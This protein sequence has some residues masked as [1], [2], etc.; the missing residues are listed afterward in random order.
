MLKL[1]QRI[2]RLGLA[3]LP[4]AASAD[5]AVII[6]VYENCEFVTSTVV[7][8]KPELLGAAAQAEL[9][10]N[11]LGFEQGIGAMVGELER[12]GVK[13][14]SV[15]RQGFEGCAPPSSGNF[16]EAIANYCG[17]RLVNAEVRVDTVV[18]AQTRIPNA[19][20]ERFVRDTAQKLKQR[21]IWDTPRIVINSNN[22]NECG[23]AQV[24]Q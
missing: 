10:A 8:D 12:N 14:I 13:T 7:V 23:T 18:F 1:T 20:F 6:G 2:V 22:S 19:S 9:A 21:G 3:L 5:D 24:A 16:V 15:R 11:G 17:E 4:I